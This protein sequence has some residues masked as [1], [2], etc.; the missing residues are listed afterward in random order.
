MKKIAAMTMAAVLAFSLAGCGSSPGTAESAG[1]QETVQQAQAEEGSSEAGESGMPVSSKDTII[2]ASNVE[3]DTLDPTGLDSAAIKRVY[4]QV[5]DQLFRYDGSSANIVPYAVESYEMDDDNM[6]ITLNLRKDIVFHN[7]DPADADDLVFTF[8]YYDGTSIG[9]TLDFINFDDVEKTGDY[10]VHVGLH[11]PFGALLDSLVKVSLLSESGT[12]EKG[13]QFGQEPIG[14]G[15]YKFVEWVSGD[16]IRL[17]ANENYWNGVPPIKNMIIRMI[18][19]QSV[20]MIEL[21]SGTIDVALDPLNSDVADLLNEGSDQLVV[22]SGGE[23]V[24]VFMACNYE[25]DSGVMKDKRV[26]QAIAYA[27]NTEDIA[28]V[29]YD[30]TGQGATGLIPPGVLGYD[31]S[32]KVDSILTTANE[33]K[34]KEL[35]AEAGYADGL[36]LTLITSSVITYTRA[37]EV[38][39]NQLAKVGITLDITTYDDATASAMEEGDFREDLCIRLVNINGDP[40]VSPFGTH[41]EPAKGVV[42]GRNVAKNANDPE[43]AELQALI[44]ELKVTFD[45]DEKVELLKEIQRVCNENMWWIPLCF[46]SLNEIQTSSLKG[47]MKVV[48]YE[49]LNQAY[50]E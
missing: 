46:A 35:L 39:Q 2:L 19:E 48:N 41:F 23:V 11:Y 5:F 6:G 38:I 26:R 34:A 8:Q 27:I 18:T 15:P 36:T 33:E 44:D 40:I 4:C 45:T 24:V 43:A 12:T 42:G 30:G 47:N 22:N 1:N 3:P 50:F 49:Y 21:E 9:A 16:N 13:D 7:G 14:S 25:S 20:Q 10:S 37:A 17:E 32:L 29:A 31:E 28:A